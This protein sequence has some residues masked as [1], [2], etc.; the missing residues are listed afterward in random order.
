MSTRSKKDVQKEI[1]EVNNRLLAAQEEHANLKRITNH[2]V[3]S[4]YQ[5]DLQFEGVISPLVEALALLEEELKSLPAEFLPPIVLEFYNKTEF[6]KWNELPGNSL[7]CVTNSKNEIV[8]DLREEDLSS[9]WNRGMLF[10]IHDPKSEAEIE[11][12]RKL[13]EAANTKKEFVIGDW[14]VLDEHE[15]EVKSKTVKIDIFLKRYDVLS[16]DG[17]TIRNDGGYDSIGEREDD[18]NKWMERY[19]H[20]G[21]YSCA[22]H[23]KI[24]LDSLRSFCTLIDREEGKIQ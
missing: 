16:P 17:I 6:E 8:G 19:S 24:S 20:Q 15:A 11:A 18:F 2:T 10:N 4:A 23:G 9:Y 21:Y 3:G 12:S 14:C 7:C 1:T 5:S 22:R 13:G